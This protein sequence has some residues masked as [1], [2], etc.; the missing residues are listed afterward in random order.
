MGRILFVGDSHSMGFVETKE[1][2][3][4]VFSNNDIDFQIQSNF[5]IWQENNYAEIYAKKFNQP[6]IITA[7]AGCGNHEYLN[8]IAQ[9]LKNYDNID[10]VVI[11]ST[12]W[13]RFPIAINPTL[14][15]EILPLDFFF[16]HKNEHTEN[17]LVH[18]YGIKQLQKKKDGWRFSTYAKLGPEHYSMSPISPI[19]ITNR[20]D[21]NNYSFI[22]IQMFYN[23]LTHLQSKEYLKTIE[24]CGLLC[25]KRNIPLTVWRINDRVTLPQETGT[26]YTNLENMKIVDTPAVD[27]IQ[28]HL[29]DDLTNY[30]VDKEHYNK[31]IH[32]YIAEYFIPYI[33]EKE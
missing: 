12:Y 25:E 15:E 33:L 17:D 29:S 30:M 26:Y 6:I 32:N 23:M 31:E 2:H 14:E 4:D 3:T 24:M 1:S 8:M 9:Q 13:G 21:L 22:Y 10:H 18:R 11:Q 7:F 28:N 27:Y 5:D 19:D 16:D 20:P